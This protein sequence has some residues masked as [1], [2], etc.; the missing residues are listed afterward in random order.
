MWRRLK[1]ILHDVLEIGKQSMDDV[2]EENIRD[3]REFLEEV[4]ALRLRK[5]AARHRDANQET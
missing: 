3:D 4:Q 2:I 5:H 1:G